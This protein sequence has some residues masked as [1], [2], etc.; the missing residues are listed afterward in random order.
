MLFN[1]NNLV[2]CEILSVDGSAGSVKDILFDNTNW[3]CRYLVVE[4]SSWFAGRTV[5]LSFEEIED[6]NE[7]N[8][9][10]KVRVTKQALEQYPDEST[11]NSI[12]ME[13]EIIIG[14]YW[15]WTTGSVNRISRSMGRDIAQE[16]SLLEKQ[17]AEK[18]V[19]SHLRSFREVK[20]YHIEAP[21]GD[22][23]HLYELILSNNDWKVCYLVVNTGSWFFDRTLLVPSTSL[24]T[25]R[26]ADRKVHVS[27]IRDTIKNCP[28]YDAQTEITREYEQLVHDYY[29]QQPYWKLNSAANSVT[30]KNKV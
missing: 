10:I 15:M 22:I 2:G 5:V 9:Q 26:W 18:M 27:I 21:D 8:R 28:V 29:G 25:I 16:A 20:G 24:D 3:T 6:I 19:G 1:A 4:T 17:T 30:N 7:A 14:K 11:R 13:A 12:S 23:G